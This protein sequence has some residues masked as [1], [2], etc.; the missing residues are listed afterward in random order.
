MSKRAPPLPPARVQADTTS[1]P[2]PEKVLIVTAD[3]RILVGTLSACD[4]STNL[5][6]L[7][8]SHWAQLPQRHETDEPD[9]LG[10]KQR[11]RA[12]N[13]RTRRFGGIHRDPARPVPGAR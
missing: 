3:S 6:R 11:D 7:P 1:L 2:F 5:V 4:Q 8:P 13:S 12:H 9:C 10:T